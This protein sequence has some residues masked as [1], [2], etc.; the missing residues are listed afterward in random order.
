MQRISPFLW[1]DGNAE[2]GGAEEAAE[3]YVSLFADSS[4][5]SFSRLPDGSAFGVTFT[6]D[7]L[8]VQA[9]NAA[10]APAFSE[11]TSFFVQVNDQSRIDALWAALTADGGTPGRCGWLV[12]RFGLSWQ[13]VPP[14]LGELLGD[15]DT[16]RS[17]R[18]MQ[19]MLGM[20]KIEIAG[21]LAAAEV[22]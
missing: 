9:M 1:F 16:A 22:E 5:D 15:P 13:I 2:S 12:D 20:G 4:V 14:I 18:V 10:P 8:T 21:L 7:G 3:F 11:A 6:I 19:A 17:S